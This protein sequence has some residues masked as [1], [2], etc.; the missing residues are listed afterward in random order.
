MGVP[1]SSSRSLAG[2]PATA[3]EVGVRVRREENV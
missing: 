1:D 2:R 3:Y